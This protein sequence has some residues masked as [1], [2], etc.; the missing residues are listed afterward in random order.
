MA[1]IT[2]DVPDKLAERLQAVE[3]RLPEILALVLD[4]DSA[5]VDLPT[6]ITLS[7]A[8]LEV[9]DFLAN[10]PSPQAILDF[11]I[12]PQAQERMEVLLGRSHSDQLDPEEKAE[13]DSYR[14]IYQLFILLK[15]RAREKAER[16]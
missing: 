15:A 1:T 5:F 7:T 9:L 16:L 4:D 6:T 8:W 10:S 2:L 12:S 14:Q 11:K 3:E 13:L